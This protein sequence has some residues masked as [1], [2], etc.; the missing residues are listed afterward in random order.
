M[1]NDLKRNV[2]KIY[3]CLVSSKDWLW[4]REIARRTGLNHKTVSRI[5]SNYFSH[6]ID[7]RVLESPFRVRLIKLKED[8]KLENIYTYIILKEKIKKL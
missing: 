8:V 5:L 7:E 4:I 1:R 2:A 3:K 6:F